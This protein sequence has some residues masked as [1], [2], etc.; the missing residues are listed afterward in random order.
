MYSMLSFV[1][2]KC[3]ICSTKP[4]LKKEMVGERGR[5]CYG[6]G[7]ADVGRSNSSMLIKI[8]DSFCRLLV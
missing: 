5:I 3:Y 1:G 7:D 8:A 6:G 4:R 2:G